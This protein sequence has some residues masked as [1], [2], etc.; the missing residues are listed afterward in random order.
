MGKRSVPIGLTIFLL[1]ITAPFWYASGKTKAQPVPSLNTPTINQLA[2][3]ACIEDTEFMRN[4]HMKLLHD[5]KETAV[6]SEQRIY[7]AKDGKKFEMS[8]EKTCL[9][10]HSNKTEFCDPC[11]TYAGIEAPNCWS[12]HVAPKE[13][14]K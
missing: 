11:H 8:L 2:N 3:K 1:L 12:C 13:G 14:K 9:S 5:W 10:C 6:R 4:N 7:V